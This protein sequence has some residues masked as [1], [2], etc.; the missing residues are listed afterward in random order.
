M[1]IKLI[2]STLIL[3][4][5]LTTV[6]CQPSSNIVV[7]KICK[8]DP[9]LCDDL[10]RIGDCPYQ[11]THLIR[12]RYFDKNEPSSEH[13][14]NFL[15]ELDTY[16]SCLSLRLMM[17]LTRHQERK[18]LAMENFLTTKKLMKQRLKKIK[19]TQDPHL[20]YYLW[21]HNN[22]L[23]AKS[24]FLKAANKKEVKDPKLLS[25]LAAIYA[26]NNPQYSLNLFYNALRE[27]KSVDELPQNIF[28]SIMMIFYKNKAFKHAYVWA[29]VA[30]AENKE[31]DIPINLDLILKKG[32]SHGKKLILDENILEKKAEFYHKKLT[33]GQ[34]NLRTPKLPG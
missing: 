22:D 19:S 33:E 31:D 1:I 2:K 12:A 30:Q 28:I 15:N 10:H 18:Q 27:S 17:Q 25:K 7:S 16:K 34:F 6:S 13:T 29:L 26:K 3:L 4:I 14:R 5:L 8:T 11:R 20:A 9:E 32:V 21:T 23:E 24:V